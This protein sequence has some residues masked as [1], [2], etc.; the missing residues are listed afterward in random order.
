M[1]L[2]IWV[3]RAKKGAIA[4]CAIRPT[5]IEIGA[6]SSEIKAIFERKTTANTSTGSVIKNSRQVTQDALFN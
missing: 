2:L 4:K 6:F 5:K 3:P 1:S